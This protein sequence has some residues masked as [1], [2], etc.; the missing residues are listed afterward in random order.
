MKAEWPS[1]K[2]LREKGRRHAVEELLR[3]RDEAGLKPL[4]ARLKGGS[5]HGFV[6]FRV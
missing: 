3:V 1:L 2:A 4:G 6:G 5:V